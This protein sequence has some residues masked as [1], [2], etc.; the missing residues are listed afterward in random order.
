MPN[1]TQLHSTHP[2]TTPYLGPRVND[3]GPALQRPP[4][5]P[6]RVAML[7]RQPLLGAVKLGGLCRLALSRQSSVLP[8][9]QRCL[10][11]ARI[12]QAQSLALGRLYGSD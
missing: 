6:T 4:R 1:N 5:P 7:Q 8:S 2:T 10:H 3:G 11:R 12:A 9:S